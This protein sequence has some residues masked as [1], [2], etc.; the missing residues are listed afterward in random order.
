MLLWYYCVVL[1][2]L[3]WLYWARCEYDAWGL[4]PL[5]VSH[6]HITR[7]VCVTNLIVWRNES[8]NKTETTKELQL[9]NFFTFHGK[10]V[11]WG[12]IKKHTRSYGDDEIKTTLGLFLYNCRQEINI[13]QKTNLSDFISLAK[14]LLLPLEFHQTELSWE[15]LFL[16]KICSALSL[17]LNLDKLY[18]FSWNLV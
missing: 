7:H 17:L 15:F 12:L 8:H 4:I 14:S 16:Y 10:I 9:R 6:I 2:W 18:L 5:A 11:Q 1:M 3:V 13:Q